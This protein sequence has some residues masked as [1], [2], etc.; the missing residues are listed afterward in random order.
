LSEVTL[1]PDW[2][3]VDVS[4]GFISINFLSKGSSVSFPRPVAGGGAI[5]PGK[6]ACEVHVYVREQSGFGLMLHSVTALELTGTGLALAN[7]SPALK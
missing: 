1:R 3:F 2:R 7:F 5:L 6:V 4:L